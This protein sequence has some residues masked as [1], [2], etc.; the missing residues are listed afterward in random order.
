M[1]AAWRAWGG[2][3]SADKRRRSGLRRRRRRRCRVVRSRRS[4]LSRCCH[5]V[6][7]WTIS[8]D[9]AQD[10]VTTLSPECNVPTW[11][12]SLCV[13]SGHVE[14]TGRP[15][16]DLK[17]SDALIAARDCHCGKMMTRSASQYLFAAVSPFDRFLSLSLRN[18]K[19]DVGR[20]CVL[21]PLPLLRTPSAENG[22]CP[23]AE[24]CPAR[25]G[26]AEVWRSVREDSHMMSAEGGGGRDSQNWVW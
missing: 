6:G 2:S 3:S 5:S 4:G 9:V 25:S 12:P 10:L 23:A 8:H 17:S 11:L 13:F 16:A 19:F 21:Q 15:C 20:H 7:N 18:L 14:M 22:G 24:S 26:G 1:A